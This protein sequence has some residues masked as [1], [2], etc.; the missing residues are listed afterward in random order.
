MDAH[1]VFY[2]YLYQR[3][4]CFF[5]KAFYLGFFKTTVSIFHNV[6]ELIIENLASHQNTQ[7]FHLSSEVNGPPRATVG[8]ISHFDVCISNWSDQRFVNQ[9]L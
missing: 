1:F 5:F 6:I 8:N 4:R 2:S 3:Y 7:L 9:K